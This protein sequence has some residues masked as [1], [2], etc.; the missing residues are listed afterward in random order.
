MDPRPGPVEVVVLNGKGNG[1]GSGDGNG[2]GAP[3]R[4]ESM[5]VIATAA[6][7]GAARGDQTRPSGVDG[8]VAT[9][10]AQWRARLREGRNEAAEVVTVVE[11][12]LAEH[13]QTPALLRVLGEAYLRLGRSDLAAAQFRAASARRVRRA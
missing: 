5:P 6:D 11:R 4:V 2:T 13:G 9:E 10:I 12:R 7:S 8:D 1:H 3:A